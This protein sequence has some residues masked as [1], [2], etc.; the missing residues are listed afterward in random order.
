MFH[1]TPTSLF[2]NFCGAR[3][4]MPFV[5]VLNWSPAAGRYDTL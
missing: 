2:T 1:L 4:I 3:M 5:N